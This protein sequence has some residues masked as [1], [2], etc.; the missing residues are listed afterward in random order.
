MW[1]M[2]GVRVG[3]REAALQQRQLAAECMCIQMH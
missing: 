1:G 2:W 3:K